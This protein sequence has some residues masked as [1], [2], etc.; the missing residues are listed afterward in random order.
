MTMLNI[1]QLNDRAS[2]YM[3]PKLKVLQRVT[4]KLIIMVGDFW[5]IDRTNRQKIIKDI[6][7]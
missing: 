2:K 5:I 3:K 1:Y 7:D 6:L 4:D